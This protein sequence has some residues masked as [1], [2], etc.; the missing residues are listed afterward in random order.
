MS[1]LIVIV[2]LLLTP[3]IQRSRYVRGRKRILVGY[4]FVACCAPSVAFLM[5]EGIP[6]G[7]VTGCSLTHGR[8]GPVLQVYLD[9]N[10]WV[11]FDWTNLA[12]RGRCLPHGTLVE[13][14]RGEFGFRIGGRPPQLAF[15]A[16]FP[17]A[18]FTLLGITLIVLG[19][20]GKARETEGDHRGWQVP[21]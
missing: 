14:R 20:L 3:L 19:I 4:F 10:E 6:A 9:N 15:A 16:F 21:H 11:Q 8:T 7:H 12:E 1:L 17:A 5:L 2:L 13:K 18:S